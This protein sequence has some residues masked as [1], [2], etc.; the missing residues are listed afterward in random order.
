MSGADWAQ[1]VVVL[2]PAVGGLILL[3]VIAS[4]VRNIVES[5]ALLNLQLQAQHEAT[6]RSQKVEFSQK[7]HD[8]L[9]AHSS[10]F[11][12]DIRSGSLVH[13]NLDNF[14]QPI[15]HKFTGAET[16]LALALIEIRNQENRSG[17]QWARSYDGFKNLVK[18]LYSK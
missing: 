5:F 6:L 3:F 16:E 11:V 14:L 8:V 7:L 2:V 1:F 10:N 15:W 12:K 4:W 18:E 9:V 17:S 13:S